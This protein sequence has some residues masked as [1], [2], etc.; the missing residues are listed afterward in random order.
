MNLR[1]ESFRLD[2]TLK[3]NLMQGYFMKNGINEKKWA[4]RQQCMIPF[5]QQGTSVHKRLSSEI[6][7][8]KLIKC[9]C[10]KAVKHGGK[11]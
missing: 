5:T 11:P 6:I 4:N 8:D 9:T 1:N 10:W 7:P 3:I 2:K